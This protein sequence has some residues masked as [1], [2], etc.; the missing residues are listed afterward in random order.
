MYVYISTVSRL[1]C[2]YTH[3]CCAWC[4]N[5]NV[6]VCVTVVYGCSEVPLVGM[7]LVLVGML[8][9]VIDVLVAV[10]GVLVV[11]AGLL[12]VVDG[13]DVPGDTN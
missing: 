9:I 11:V 13:V 5:V 8:V 3:R 10:A 7:L 1:G 12:V 6:V 4:R 2:G